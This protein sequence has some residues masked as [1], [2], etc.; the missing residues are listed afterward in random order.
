MRTV[1]WLP[2]GHADWVTDGHIDRIAA[3]ARPGVVVAEVTPDTADPEY[4]ELQE[5]LRALRL[6]SDAHGRRLQVILIE[7]S[8]ATGDRGEDFCKSYVN[9][10]L[11]N[12]AVVMPAFGD[13][14]A[15]EAAMKVLA[16]VF[17][18]RRVVAV[19]LS[20]IPKG[21]GG[22]HCVTLQQP[23]PSAGSP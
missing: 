9:F 12:G 4:W 1:I 22:I 14:A 19:P 8:T 5:N 6:A 23:S 10:Y 16:G 21:G 3:F 13:A 20:T 2:G 11:A 17:P 7:R 18:G 15:D